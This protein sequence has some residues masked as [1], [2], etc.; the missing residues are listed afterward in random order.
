M[1]RIPVAK[2]DRRRNTT[3]IFIR[4]DEV[5]ELTD[6][7]TDGSVDVIAL[8]IPAVLDV[9]RMLV[10]FRRFRLHGKE[11]FSGSVA[12]FSEKTMVNGSGAILDGASFSAQT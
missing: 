1:L 6:L 12:H 5:R 3:A 11:T 8:F 4:F 7:L 10:E 2:F 9:T